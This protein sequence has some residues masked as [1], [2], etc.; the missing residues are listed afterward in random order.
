MRCRAAAEHAIVMA[1]T[2]SAGGIPERNI[3]A[4]AAVVDRMERDRYEQEKHRPARRA[5]QP[6]I[7]RAA[8]TM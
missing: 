4:R 8:L 6:G 1:V 3:P 2:I 5:G 7:E